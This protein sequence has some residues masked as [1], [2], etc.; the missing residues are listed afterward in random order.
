[1]KF[2]D[3]GRAPNP[4]RVKIVLAEKNVNVETVQVDI[5]KLEQR[6]ESYAKLN[7]AQRV[8]AFETAEGVVLAE[9]LAIC[10]YLEAKFPT[11]NLFG[12]TP[13]EIGEIEMWNRRIEMGL[14]SHVGFAFRHSNPFMSEMEKPQIAAWGEA[15]KDKIPA[16]LEMLNNVV[17][18]KNYLVNNRFTMADINALVALDFMRIIKMRIP[19]HLSEL[20]RYHAALAARPTCA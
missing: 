18:G 12:A 4:R 10:R 1:M 20:T 19:E 6:S 5:N 9:S 3:S 11:P 14:F 13:L 16:E 15:C 8:P 7:P 17:S 2:Y